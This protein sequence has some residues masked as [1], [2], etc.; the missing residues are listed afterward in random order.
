MLGPGARLSRIGLS[1][2]HVQDGSAKQIARTKNFCGPIHPTRGEGKKATFQALRVGRILRERD[3]RG[4][5]AARIRST[6][7]GSLDGRYRGDSEEHAKERLYENEGKNLGAKRME[8]A[9]VAVELEKSGQQSLQ[10]TFSGS[11]FLRSSNGSVAKQAGSQN[12]LTHL[13]TKHSRCQGVLGSRQP[14]VHILDWPGNLLC[15]VFC[16]SR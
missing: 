10:K 3:S 2:P 15:I 14:I 5:G 1:L 9:G 8:G 11:L 12:K 6:G 16:L 13:K 4:I 7:G